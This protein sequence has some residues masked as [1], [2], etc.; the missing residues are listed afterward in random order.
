LSQY[1]PKA[2]LRAAEAYSDI[3]RVNLH[4]RHQIN[5]TTRQKYSNYAT[6]NYWKQYL[7]RTSACPERSRK[8]R[9]PVHILQKRSHSNF[10]II[11]GNLLPSIS[12]GILLAHILEGKMNPPLKRLDPPNG[13]MRHHVS[14]SNLVL[15]LNFLDLPKEKVNLIPPLPL[16]FQL[17]FFTG[18][19]GARRGREEERFLT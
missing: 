13:P 17:G 8:T 2:H 6:V 18:G 19:L 7:P 12:S 15:R 3:F 11:L 4:E 1:A 14:S 9:P 5:S 16:E 10:Q